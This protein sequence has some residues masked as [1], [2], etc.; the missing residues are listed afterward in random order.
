MIISMLLFVEGC[1]SYDSSY[2]ESS[3]NLVRKSNPSI[4]NPNSY[5]DS[6][7]LHRALGEKYYS[8]RKY[9]LAITEFSTA[10]E[11]VPGDAATYEGLG[12]SYREIGEF[13]KAIEAFERGSLLKPPTPTSPAHAKLHNS[14]AL[15][16]DMMGNHEEAITEYDKA[17]K[18]DPTNDSFYNNKGFSYLL[19]GQVEAAI[20]AFKKAIETNPNNKTAYGNLGYA[21]GLKGMYELALN[22][23]KLAGDEASAYNNLGYIYT[24][25]GKLT[26]ALESYNNALKLNPNIPNIY[27]NKGLAYELLGDTANAIQAYQ[28]FLNST[29]QTS[30]AEEAFERIQALKRKKAENK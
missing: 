19:Q 14:T 25:N 8:D 15:T 5:Q 6:V 24:K 2:Q 21:Y 3:A 20:S 12:R 1:S 28:E 27:Y 22:Q 9:N 29:T 13:D 10:L 23:F 18:L 17:I 7:I 30:A 26:E 4:N 11:M 16:Y